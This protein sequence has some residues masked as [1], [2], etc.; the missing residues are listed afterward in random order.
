MAFTNRFYR[1]LAFQLLGTSSTT[2][3]PFGL[4]MATTPLKSNATDGVNFITNETNSD[5]ANIFLNTSSHNVSVSN[6]VTVTRSGGCKTTTTGVYTIANNGK[7]DITIIG[8][9]LCSGNYSYTRDDGL[10]STSSTGRVDVTDLTDPVVIPAGGAGKVVYTLSLTP[11][12]DM[13]IV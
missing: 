5:G 13:V 11:P 2:V 12:D 1:M 3:K 7:T 8:V 10:G 6:S 9:V 4:L